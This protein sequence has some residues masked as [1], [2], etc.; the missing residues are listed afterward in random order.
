M[1]EEEEEERRIRGKYDGEEEEERRRRRRARHED[2]RMKSKDSFADSTSRTRSGRHAS[3]SKKEKVKTS[4]GDITLDESIAEEIMVDNSN[5][6]AKEVESERMEQEQ[7]DYEQDF[8]SVIHTETDIS[9]TI[10]TMSN[11]N[12]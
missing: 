10:D 3:R 7:A 4:K 12:L 6:M 1:R 8:E 5:S 2:K 9:S 11:S